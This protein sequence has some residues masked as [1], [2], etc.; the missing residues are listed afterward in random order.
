MNTQIFKKRVPIGLLFSL[1][2]LI[3]E[4]DDK[5]YTLTF[6]SFK[7]GV[8]HNFISSFLKNCSEY[9]HVSKRIYVERKTTY[10][11]FLTVVRQI[12]NHNSVPYTSQIKYDKSNYSIIYNIVHSS[13]Q[14]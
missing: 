9:Y 8:F 5:T 11:T 10:N 6:E 4:K 14:V 3:C 2:D 13:G 1:L 12:C 7:K